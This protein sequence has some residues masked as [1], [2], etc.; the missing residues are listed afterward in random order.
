MTKQTPESVAEMLKAQLSASKKTDDNARTEATIKEK[1]KADTHEAAPGSSPEDSHVA[2]EGDPTPEEKVVTE[3]EPETDDKPETDA[4]DEQ[5]PKDEKAKDG[6]KKDNRKP[7][8]ERRIDELVGELKAEKAHREALEQ[9]L[10]KLKTTVEAPKK[11]A[12][13][14]N[15]LAELEKSRIEKYL[16]EDSVL[17]R[18]QRREMSKDQLEEWVIEDPVAAQE[19][20]A[21]RVVRRRDERQADLERV[22]ADT[23]ANTIINSQRQSEAR[24]L[25]KHPD[26]DFS[27]QEK[28]LIA[29]GMTLQ[30]ARAELLKSN[31]KAR[32]IAKIISEPGAQEKYLLKSNGPELL[33]QEMESRLAKSNGT[34]PKDSDEDRDAKIAEEAAEAE[35]QRQARVD[36]G[37]T[38]RRGASASEEQSESYK[39]QLAIFKSMGKTKEDLDRALARRKAMNLD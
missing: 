16:K 7:K 28:A 18:E 2:V 9:E 12:D 13:Q 27:G 24:V 22:N 11:E 31:P 20:M 39:K 8:V 35:R 1:A 32:M 5:K 4:A 36:S 14:T 19:W 34:K 15:K 23:E 21:E 3:T 30:E 33:M 6:E 38:S 25:A 17:P 37:A 26:L 29:R 10:A